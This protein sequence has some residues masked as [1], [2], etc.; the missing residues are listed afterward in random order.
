MLLGPPPLERA[1]GVFLF[2]TQEKYSYKYSLKAP[3]ARR[4]GGEGILFVL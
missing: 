4:Q 1:A 3:C 2:A